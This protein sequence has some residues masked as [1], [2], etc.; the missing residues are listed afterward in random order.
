LNKTLLIRRATAK[1][2]ARWLD[3]ERPGDLG[4]LLQMP[5]PSEELWQA[6]LTEGAAA[7][8]ADLLLVAERDDEVIGQ[9]GLF[10][11]VRHRAGGMRWGWASR[12]RPPRKGRASAPR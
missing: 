5:Y 8:K 2:A 10:S 3:H 4:G 6:R 12:S 7:V 1:D 11:P 9:A